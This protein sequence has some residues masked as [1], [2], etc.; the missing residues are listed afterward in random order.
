MV[1]VIGTYKKHLIDLWVFCKDNFC[2]DFYYT[3]NNKRFFVADPYT[4][5]NLFANSKKIVVVETPTGIDGIAVVWRGVGGDKARD[6]VKI[7]APDRDTAYKLLDVLL[8]NYN[9]ELY[10]KVRKDFDYLDIL[11][12]FG[13]R[14]YHNRGKEVLLKRT[15]VR[16]NK[17]DIERHRDK[18]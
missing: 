11:K 15:P 7:N 10:V 14:W 18:S 3:E 5:K 12:K 6:Y 8:D 2:S 1:K 9:K 17:N 4:I 13:F 16:R